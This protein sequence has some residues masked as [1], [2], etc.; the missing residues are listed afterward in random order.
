MHGVHAKH[1]LSALSEFKRY[2]DLVYLSLYKPI[3]E[4]FILRCL[5]NKTLSVLI[6][7]LNIQ[8]IILTPKSSFRPE[9]FLNDHNTFNGLLEDVVH[10]GGYLRPAQ[11]RE[12]STVH[13]GNR[14]ASLYLGRTE[15]Q[16]LTK[17]KGKAIY[18]TY[19]LPETTDGHK[20]L[21]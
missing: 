6:V 16:N 7:I 2:M 8:G 10:T 20:G 13:K 21:L 5:P 15:K 3:Y 1:I 11:T 9:E 14:E 19:K 12:Q 4:H 18:I 17:S